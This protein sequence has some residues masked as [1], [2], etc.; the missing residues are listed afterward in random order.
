MLNVVSFGKLRLSVND[1]KFAFNS[2]DTMLNSVDSSLE[3]MLNKDRLV[4][5]LKGYLK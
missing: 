3:E 2:M 4:D 5:L 1:I